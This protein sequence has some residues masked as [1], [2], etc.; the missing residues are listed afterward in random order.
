MSTLDLASSHHQ[1]QKAEL[2]N[3]HLLSDATLT[4][5]PATIITFLLS[6]FGGGRSCLDV[7][8][9]SHDTHKVNI[10]NDEPRVVLDHWITVTRNSR[11]QNTTI[12]SLPA[13]VCCCP[14]LVLTQCPLPTAAPVTASS[15]SGP[16][17]RPDNISPPHTGAKLLSCRYTSTDAVLFSH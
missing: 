8:I 1:S 2:Q 11:F 15:Q 10:N 7:W 16:G 14:V 6:L 13:D 4:R 9:S 5:A 12:V 17:F 3:N